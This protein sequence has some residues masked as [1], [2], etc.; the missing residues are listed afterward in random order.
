MTS[1]WL[2]LGLGLLLFAVT[3]WVWVPPLGRTHVT[4]A[5]ID[6]DFSAAD[7]QREEQFHDQVRPWGYLSLF[8][9]VAIPTLLT[10]SGAVQRVTQGSAGN[11]VL[12]VC[13]AALCVTAVTWI[14][15][16][17]PSILVRT[18]LIAVGLATGSWG[19]WWR[20]M[21]VGQSV[22]LA[23]TFIALVAV[24]GAARAWP[25][26]WWI[27]VAA[28]AVVVVI[29]M[30]F[31]V[32]VVIEPLF[33]RFTSLADGPLRD[34]LLALADGDGVE[35]R[36]VLVADASKRT[37]ALNAYVSGLGPTRRVVVHDTMIERTSDAEVVAVVAHELGHV[38][39]RDVWFG[40][41]AGAAAAASSVCA[42]GLVLDSSLVQQWGHFQNAADP[43]VVGVVMMASAWLGLLMSPLST[44]ISRRI[45]RRADV[46][47]LELTDDP[48]TV[49]A[50]HRALALTNI[51]TL[52]PNPL[53]YIWF[54]T[55]PTSPERI[56]AA[57]EWR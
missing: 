2:G 38:V 45:E 34:A 33:N 44:A 48:E 27:A 25:R 43:A 53:R 50:M 26:D 49:V 16:L 7:R 42:A 28:A 23:L 46:H 39:A 55:H 12:S 13:S 11:W 6:A 56:K 18:K 15:G 47:C 51:G 20:D 4:S 54:A 14:V 10:L 30:S 1:A 22:G 9:G 36:D 5:E 52:E 40:T 35:I 21:A 37:S 17:L 31:I 57:R 3:C 41:L 24:V 29:S 32:P 19:R 8:I